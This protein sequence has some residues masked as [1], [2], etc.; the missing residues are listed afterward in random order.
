MMTTAE[1][2]LEGL[3]RAEAMTAFVVLRQKGWVEAVR[4]TWGERLYYIPDALIPSLTVTYVERVGRLVELYLS[5][6]QA[7][8]SKNNSIRSDEVKSDKVNLVREGETRYCSRASSCNGLDGER[9]C[10]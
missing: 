4:K 9:R 6:H 7:R 1:C 3:S 8:I 5:G 10:R 2:A